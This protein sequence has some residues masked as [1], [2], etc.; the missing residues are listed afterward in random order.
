M[1]KP[2]QK[3]RTEARWLEVHEAALLLEAARTYRPAGMRAQGH[4]GAIPAGAKPY[5]HPIVATFLLRGGRGS[6]I[7]GLA[8]DD[9]SFYRH[10]ITFRSQP[11]RRLK[12][13]TSLRPVSLWPQLEAILRE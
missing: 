1:D 5:S 6:E 3:E 9:V 10:R 4:G 7:G 13:E 11:W 12:I 8:A 2:S